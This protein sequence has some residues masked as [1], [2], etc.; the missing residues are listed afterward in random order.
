MWIIIEDTWWKPLSWGYKN[1]LWIFHVLE[2]TFSLFYKTPASGG[3]TR[4]R[5]LTAETYNGDHIFLW[6][7]YHFKGQ[8]RLQHLV[9]IAKKSYYKSCFKKLKYMND[10]SQHEIPG[11]TPQKKI[12]LLTNFRKHLMVEH[13][14]AT[15]PMT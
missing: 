9:K 13:Q 12:E 3:V 14:D 11:L 15:C 1:K 2:L 10:L 7:K 5:V 6:L 8:T 4:T